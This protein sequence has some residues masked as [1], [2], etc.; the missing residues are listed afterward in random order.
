[1][2][3]SRRVHQITS[4]TPSSTPCPFVWYPSYIDEGGSLLL[5]NLQIFRTVA[6]LALGLSLS[7][8][9]FQTLK[10]TTSLRIKEHLVELAE[11]ELPPKLGDMYTAIVLACLHCLDPENEAFGTEQELADEDGILVGVRFVENVLIK[12]SK[13]SI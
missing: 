4:Q 3:P 11:T 1:M 10:S 6:E 8:T 7:D 9:Q 5:Y 2:S 12:M 13:I